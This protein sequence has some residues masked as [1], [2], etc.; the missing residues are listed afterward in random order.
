ML[1]AIL[2]CAA[3]LGCFSLLALAQPLSPPTD[4]KGEAAKGKDDGKS[5]TKD[6]AKDAPKAKTPLDKLK[7]PKDAIVLV[8]DN[9]LDAMSLFPKSVTMAFDE[10]VVLKERIKALE[11]QL[12]A[13][14]KIPFSCKLNGKLEGD[15]IFFRAEYVFSTELPNT[16]VL[17]G[18]NGGFLLNEEGDLDGQP[19]ILDYSVDEGF[20]ALVGKEAKRHV[21][22]L[23]FKVPVRKSFTGGT[24]RFIELGLPGT[25]VTI[26]N[27]E[28]PAQIKEL[29]WNDTR[30]KTRTPGR[31]ELNPDKSSKTLSLAWKEP[32]SPSANALPANAV[33]QIRVDVQATHVDIAAELLLE[34]SR[35]QTKEWRLLLPPQANVEVEAPKGLTAELLKPEGNI[36]AIKV[37]ITAERWKV[38]VLLRVPRPK[39]EGSVTVGPFYVF[40]A[41]QQHGMITVKMP[42]EVSFGQ[43]LVFARTDGVEQIK[44]AETE[45][46]FRYVAPLVSDKNPKVKPTPKA[47][48]ELTWRFE[49]NQLETHVLHDLKVRTVNQGWE[50]DAVTRIKVKAIYSTINA[51]DLKLPQPRLNGVEMLGTAAP[52]L[53]FP[54]SLPWAGIGTKFHV[55]WTFPSTDEPAA[56][57]ELGKALN[58]DRPLKLVAQNATGKTR[59]FLER[60]PA[61]KQITIELKNSFR[62]SFSTPR[63]RMELPRP[64]NTLDRGVKVSI[65]ADDRIELLHGPEGAEEPVPDRDHFEMTLDQTP[66]FVDLAWRPYDREIVAQ[67]TI[68]VTLH[69]HTA[70]VK[71]TLRFPRDQAGAGADAKNGQV[72]LK[73]PRGLDK[74]SKISGGAIVNHD[75]ARHTLLILPDANPEKVDLVL[76]YDLAM[77]KTHLL[78]VVQ[79]WP[80]SASQMDAKVR[81]WAPAEVKARLPEE[82]VN[83]GLWKER[84]IEVMEGKKQFPALVLQGY[85]SSLPLTLKIEALAATTTAALVADRAFIQVRMLDDGSQQCRARYLLSKLPV[86]HLDVE[87]PIALSLFRPVFELD[88][89]PVR[90]DKLDATERVLRLKLY[91]ELV[92]LPAVLEIS[93][94]IPADGMDRNHFWRTTLQAPVFRSEEMVIGQMRWQLTTPAPMIAASLG[95]S[96]RADM[97][98]G[99]HSWLATPD[100][101][102]PAAEM[103]AWPAEKEPAQPAAA[104]I[105]SFTHVSL[106][107]ETVY[108]LPRWG[109]L[110]GCSGLLLIVTL[111]GYFAPRPRWAAWLL[112]PSPALALVAVALFSPAAM[113][114]VLFGLQPGLLLFLLFV[115]IHW[116]LQERYRRQLVFLPGFTRAKPGSTMVRADVAKR[117]REASTVDAPGTPISSEG[118]AP[119]G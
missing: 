80:A 1:R 113:P 9:V 94:T 57:D 77:T 13:D 39:L 79:V 61:P 27:L 37:P 97:Q 58:P 84:G 86:D 29:L 34:D 3:A 25:P 81:V 95:R 28:L 110:L 91:P 53:A 8:V 109:W 22:T 70:Q 31:W 55:P 6:A 51:I 43:R 92:T 76:Y 11:R 20:V 107:P 24:E 64:L 112:L 72:M 89:R 106:Q 7:L 116:L 78:H 5:K 69:E 52:G 17:L 16:T 103:E 111:G 47:L 90:F 19:P 96:V 56:F 105:Y 49:K 14:K 60:T 15:F 23:N 117:P 54:G 93:Y 102:V 108:H 26:V 10:Y 12:K 98:W 62:I 63:I 75:A 73:L 42:T 40:E 4:K 67:S 32:M 50:V 59:V 114:A 88:G 83:R 118:A 100:V 46:Q 41:R 71:Q 104:I 45:A 21:L 38:T 33:G 119:E 30:E 115:G 82:L 99:L 68:D 48:L 44:N 87:L 101:A 35:L 18:L 74:I 65:Q 85:G 36:H 66:G 2:V